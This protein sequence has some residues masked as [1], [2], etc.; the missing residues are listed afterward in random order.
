M[1]FKVLTFESGRTNI[2][3]VIKYT[4]RMHTPIERFS[5][6]MAHYCSKVVQYESVQ[7]FTSDLLKRT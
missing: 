7:I 6:H 3:S 2:D 1:C 5:L 4:C